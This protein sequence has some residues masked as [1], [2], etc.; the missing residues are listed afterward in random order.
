MARKEREVPLFLGDPAWEWVDKDN[1]PVRYGDRGDRCWHFAGGFT[2]PFPTG[3]L[4]LEGISYQVKRHQS[5]D[6]CSWPFLGRYQV[7]PRQRQYSIS[8]GGL[9]KMVVSI[10]MA[11]RR[12]GCPWK[13]GLVANNVQMGLIRKMPGTHCPERVRRPW[14]YLF[15]RNNF[16]PRRDKDPCVYLRFTDPSPRHVKTQTERLSDV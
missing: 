7:N 8:A 4:R 10:G 9:M 5:L 13:V 2:F 3:R 16:W 15:R 6:G 1:R 14:Q 11:E 12:R